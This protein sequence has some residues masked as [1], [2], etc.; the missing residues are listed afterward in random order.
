MNYV[1]GNSANASSN[2]LQQSISSSG[3]NKV[4]SLNVDASKTFDSIR[5]HTK[6][7]FKDGITN[8]IN[9]ILN[10]ENK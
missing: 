10:K 8:T 5:S 6:V 9:T 2:N 7:S 4:F 1:F 3:S